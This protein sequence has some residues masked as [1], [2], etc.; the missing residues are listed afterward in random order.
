MALIRM[1]EIRRRR[2]RRDKLRHLREKY[3]KAKNDSERNSI[4]AKMRRVN[5]RLSREQFLGPLE[6]RAA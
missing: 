5:P 2:V 1:K 6:R 3:R 4:L